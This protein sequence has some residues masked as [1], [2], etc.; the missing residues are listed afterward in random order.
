M[1]VTLL[2]IFTDVKPVQRSNAESSMEVTLFPKT[3]N[4]I[5][6]EKDEANLDTK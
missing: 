6:E 5:E 2:D 4:F 1:E 3:T